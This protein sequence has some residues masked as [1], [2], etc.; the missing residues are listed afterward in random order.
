MI[1]NQGQ[2]KFAVILLNLKV[3]AYGCKILMTE[4]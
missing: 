2:R 3:M 4:V 1:Y